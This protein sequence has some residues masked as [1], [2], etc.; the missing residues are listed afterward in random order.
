MQFSFL[1]YFIKNCLV[2][3]CHICPPWAHLLVVGGVSNMLFGEIT[4]E[5]NESAQLL[6]TS[7]LHWYK[8]YT[9]IF[10]IQRNF[11]ISSIFH[12]SSLFFLLLGFN[13][14]NVF[15]IIS[16]IIIIISSLFS[17]SPPSF[18]HQF[19]LH[20]FLQRKWSVNY[21]HN[22]FFIPL[23]SSFTFSSLL[24]R[25]FLQFL[26]HHHHHHHQLHHLHHH[27]HHHLRIFITLSLHY[28]SYSIY[29]TI[30]SFLSTSSS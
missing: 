14:F 19:L 1:F 9:S 25:L 29:I 8:I 26:H 3:S 23:L 21:H 4:Y 16:I 11:I 15:N 5:A 2:L 7:S 22:I 13:C 20:L 12:I 28:T 24:F 27:H 18:P 10:N 6:F 30:L 17:S